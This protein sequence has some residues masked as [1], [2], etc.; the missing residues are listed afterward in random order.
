[1]SAGGNPRLFTFLRPIWLAG[2]VIVVYLLF[3]WVSHIDDLEHTEITPWAPQVALLI[4]VVMYYGARAA[5]L[6]IITPGI[7]EWAMRGSALLSSEVLGATICIGCSYTIAGLVLRHIQQRYPQPTIGWFATF[8]VVISVAALLD[9]L[10]YSVFLTTTGKLTRGL[11]LTAVRTDWV[12]DVNGIVVLVPLFVLLYIGE[13]G[14]LREVGAHVGLIMVQAASLACAFLVTFPEIWG[15]P[16]DDTRNPFYLLYLPMIWIALR[17]GACVT[18]IALAALQLGIVV[19]VARQNTP[20]SFLSIQVLMVFLT[21]TG[22]FLGISVSEN[23]RI[24]QLIKSK[25]VALSRLNARMAVSEL[26]AAIGHELNNPLAALVNYLRSASLMLELPGFDRVSLQ[27]TLAKAHGEATR[28]INVLR[29]LREFFRSGVVRRESVDPRMLAAEAL[30]AMQVRFRQANIAAVVGASADIPLIEADPLQVAMV[31]QNLLAN[32]YDAVQACGAERGRIVIGVAHIGNEVLMTVSD[33]GTG[34][35]D[36]LRDRLFRPVD[37][38]KPA[39]MGL[40]LAICRSL[41]EANYG[42]ISVVRSGV[43][44]TCIGF[45][46]PVAKPGDSRG[47]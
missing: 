1:M 43:D 45:Y 25:D 18:A 31:L 15:F 2:T 27:N 20:E 34:I 10:L 30:A 14:K 19:F 29:K 37:S 21:C 44:G 42:R 5:P 24:N 3:D 39:G 41:V 23:A 33:T 6:T 17:W 8:S 26:N 13:P 12:G 38:T 11:L 40:G 36:A 32:A 16:Q 7:A 4:A 46:I 28:S 9:A 22:L 35:P 47:A